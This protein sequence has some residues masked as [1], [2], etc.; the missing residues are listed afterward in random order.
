SSGNA[1][2]DLFFKIGA[3]RGQPVERLIS[4]FKIAYD[5]NPN[6]AVRILL[7]TCDV[8]QGAGERKIFRDVMKWLEKYE[9]T[10]AE[11]IVPKIAE[12]G[13]FD[14]LLIFQTKQL[15]EVALKIYETALRNK[16]ALAFKFM[17]SE[18]SAKKREYLLLRN[19]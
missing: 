6:L 7:W 15:Q 3:M 9:P 4:M 19:Y 18:G 14:D 1:C 2:V 12:L 11:L 8:R 17:P 10:V 16:N 5:E 13:R